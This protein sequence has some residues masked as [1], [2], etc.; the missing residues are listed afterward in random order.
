MPIEHKPTNALPK[1]YR[2]PHGSPY[3]VRDKETWKTLAYRWFLNV[4]ELIYFNFQTLNTDEINWYLRRNV[5][6]KDSTD[7]LNWAFSSRANP[8]IIYQPP[9]KPIVVRDTIEEFNDMVG[10]GTDLGKALEDGEQHHGVTHKLHFALDLAHFAEIGLSIAGIELLHGVAGL[11]SEAI[12][13]PAMGLALTGM[14]LGMGHMDAIDEIKSD[15]AY[16]G[17]SHGVVLGA[18]GEQNDFI[19]A[20][21][22]VNSQDNNYVYP[23][24]RKEFQNAYLW[25]LLHGL[26][27]GKKL[28][29]REKLLFFKHL[30]SQIGMYPPGEFY[31]HRW[32]YPERRRYTYYLDCAARFLGESKS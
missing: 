1:D 2:P 7:G 6:C 17:I 9:P 16:S 27:Y 22:V 15:K 24:K 30:E 12:V 31:I 8:G 11:V 29:N 23:E 25:G 26:E 4:E 5:G 14:A 32:R 28:T 3:K 21:F 18:A 20:N 10:S 13:G 19:K